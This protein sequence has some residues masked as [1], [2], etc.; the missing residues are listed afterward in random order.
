MAEVVNRE[1]KKKKETEKDRNRKGDT[2]RRGIIEDK[3]KEASIL[4]KRSIGTAPFGEE[5]M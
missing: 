3:M 1:T 5:T 2:G 4:R